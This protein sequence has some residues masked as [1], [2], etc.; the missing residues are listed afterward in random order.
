MATR[1]SSEQ[2]SELPLFELKER[3]GKTA[4]GKKFLQE[5]IIDRSSAA[6]S[7]ALEKCFHWARKCGMT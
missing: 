7:V 1:E 4:E 6:C 3:Y 2:F 5:S